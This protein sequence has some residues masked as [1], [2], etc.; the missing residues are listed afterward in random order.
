MTGEGVNRT[1]K[2]RSQSWDSWWKETSGEESN[3]TRRPKQHDKGCVK[4][5]SRR[6]KGVRKCLL[7]TGN[8]VVTVLLQSRTLTNPDSWLGFHGHRVTGCR[9][10]HKRRP[11]RHFFHFEYKVW[12]SRRKIMRGKYIRIQWTE[13]KK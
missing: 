7:S 12:R 10:R 6:S 2:R 5:K 13:E 9:S 8:S 11:F 3:W 1:L 4:T